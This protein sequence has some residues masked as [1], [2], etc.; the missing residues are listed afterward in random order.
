[1]TLV[2]RPHRPRPSIARTTAASGVVLTALLAGMLASPADAGRPAR[3]KTTASFSAASAVRDTPVSVTG[4]VKD[5]VK[6]KRKVRLQLKTASGWRTQDKD[7]TTRK[8]EYAFAVPTW[9]NRSAK[10]RVLA[11]RKGR[12]RADASKSQRITVTEPYAPAGDPGAWKHIYK[13]PIRLNPCQTLTYRVNAAGGR[14]DPA[15][16]EALAHAAVARVSQASGVKFRYLGPTD[17][18][19]QGS[20]SSIP[21]DTDLLVSWGTDAQTKLDIGPDYAGRGGAG[22]AVW[23]RDARGRR[24]ALARNAGVVLDSEELNLD[25]PD[26]LLVLMHEVGHAMGLGHVG[27]AAQVMNAGSYGLPESQWGAGDLT[28]FE[29]VGVMA[30]CVRPDRRRGRVSAPGDLLTPE[31]P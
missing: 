12:A 9:W 14:P 25:V 17:A 28:G 22:K 16:A 7:R 13:Y 15:T 26:T 4:K 3:T 24:M 8:G 29:K 19:F 10:V 1:M 18:I 30:G 6:G 2:P 11:T 20:G 23:G 27:D 31:L 5:K 21:K